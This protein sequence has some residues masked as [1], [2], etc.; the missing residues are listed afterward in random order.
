MSRQDNP[1]VQFSVHRRIT[2]TMAI[3]GVL[4]D[5]RARA[6]ASLEAVAATTPERLWMGE[7]GLIDYWRC[8]S[9]ELDEQHLAGLRLF[10]ALAV[11][12]GLLTAV[13]E[14][15]FFAG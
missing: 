10:F 15:R 8:M 9:Y 14:I 13:P 1:I 11:K 5:A 6:F 4:T 12:H 2:L 7:A 3:A